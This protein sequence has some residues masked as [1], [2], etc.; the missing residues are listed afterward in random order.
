MTLT[1]ETTERTDGAPVAPRAA[2]RRPGAGHSPS[3]LA[4]RTDGAGGGDR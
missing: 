3:D 2:T 4:P 1:R